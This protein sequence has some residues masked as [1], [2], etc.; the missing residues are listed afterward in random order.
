[1]ADATQDPPVEKT[2]EELE[3]EET[4]RRERDAAWKKTT[5]QLKGKVSYRNSAHSNPRA[6]H[7][8]SIW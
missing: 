4:A 1:M 2:E 6:P 3:A 5:K 7:G 8:S